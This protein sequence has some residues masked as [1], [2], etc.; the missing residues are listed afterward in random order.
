M[1]CSC[2]ICYCSC[3]YVLL[4]FT[5][6]IMYLLY[7]VP[8]VCRWVEGLRFVQFCVEQCSNTYSL[9]VCKNTCPFTTWLTT[10]HSCVMPT[11]LAFPCIWKYFTHFVVCLA[12]TCRHVCWHGGCTACSMHDLC[13]H[14]SVLCMG[15]VIA[16]CLLSLSMQDGMTPLM[17]ASENLHIQV[18]ET[19]IS[20][21]AD[22]NQQNEV[23]YCNQIYGVF[24]HFCEGAANC[25]RTAFQTVRRCQK[26]LPL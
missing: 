5:H 9:C 23:M 3:G 25:C 6:L 18:V 19:L 17:V 8:V 10:C 21:G 16:C 26:D 4:T 13:H 15:V 2:C 1:L 11:P 20:R 24:L 7:K 12:Q 14:S 22:I